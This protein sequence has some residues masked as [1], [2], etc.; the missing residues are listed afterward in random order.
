MTLGE[1]LTIGQHWR[2]RRDGCTVRI[3]QVHRADRLVE[4][5]I[6]T[7]LLHTSTPRTLSFRQLADER[8]YEVICAAA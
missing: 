1:H 3:R 5:D 2:R 8:W 4:I 6:V 7:P